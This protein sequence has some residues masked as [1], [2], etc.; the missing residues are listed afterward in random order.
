MA[1][2][3]EWHAQYQEMVDAFRTSKFTTVQNNTHPDI[4]RFTHFIEGLE[5]QVNTIGARI[6]EKEEAAH[7]EAVKLANVWRDKVAAVQHNAL[8][9]DYH[10]SIAEFVELHDEERF[11]ANR[12]EKM[13]E[14]ANEKAQES[15]PIATMV[16]AFIRDLGARAVRLDQKVIDQVKQSPLSPEREQLLKELGIC[17][18]D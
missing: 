1:H 13:L 8:K 2:C 16:T 5:D 3:K 4:A 18:M 15:R 7:V 9:H 14:A 12:F 17:V 10:D 6:T 11:K